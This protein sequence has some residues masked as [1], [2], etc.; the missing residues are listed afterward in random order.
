MGNECI[1]D[2]FKDTAACLLQ[3]ERLADTAGHF[4][5]VDWAFAVDHLL[6]QTG[7]FMLS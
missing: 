4:L 6:N 7:H 2:V 1:A 3:A 5:T